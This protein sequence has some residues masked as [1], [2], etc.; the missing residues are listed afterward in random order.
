MRFYTLSKLW[1]GENNIKASFSECFVMNT[2]A[3]KRYPKNPVCVAV[4][5][6]ET[7]KNIEKYPEIQ[8]IMI[9]F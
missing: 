6:S 9:P 2:V 1:E 3:K 7:M 4:N 8:I 5:V